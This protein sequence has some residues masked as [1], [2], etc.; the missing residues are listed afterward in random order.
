MMI[1]GVEDEWTSASPTEIED[2]MAAVRAWFEKWADKIAPGGAELDLTRTAKTVRRDAT[3]R[4]TVTDGPYAELKEVIG[5]VVVLEA[6]S[7]DEAVEIAGGWP[8][9]STTNSVEVRP[10]I[11]H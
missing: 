5:G 9:I 10:V 3:G 6:D 11:E 8:H 7:I 1:H 4:H 2:G